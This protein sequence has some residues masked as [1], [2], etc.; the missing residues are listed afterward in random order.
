MIRGLN[1]S[2]TASAR[3][4]IRDFNYCT[5]GKVVNSDNLK[6]GFIDVQPLTNYLDYS[7]NEIQ[8]PIIY[9]V[10]VVFPNT[11]M[12]SITYPVNQ[13]DGVLLVFTQQDSNA[14]LNGVKEPHL[15]LKQSWLALNHAVAFIGF[16]TVDDSCFNQNN[17]KNQLD[18]ND[19]NIVHN[20]KTD[21]EI[22]L[23]L[24]NDGNVKLKTT[25]N[26]Y[27]ESKEVNVKAD[28]VNANSALIKTD[29]DIE[30]KGLSVYKNLTKHTHKYT[31]NG[32]PMESQVPTTV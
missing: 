19:L 4:A 18:M 24:K 11:A 15:P 17:Y 28:I 21:N 31:D 27:T 23:S 26:I 32:N 6:D 20:K 14:Y 30:I 10:P 22:V 8:S 9:N 13:G 25:K 2:M 1:E 3:L 16:S 5:F 12:T 29:N 7:M